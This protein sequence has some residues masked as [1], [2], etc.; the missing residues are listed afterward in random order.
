MILWNS[1][2]SHA[3][4]QNHCKSEEGS[5]H[6]N[7]KG[8]GIDEWRGGWVTAVWN[9]WRRGRPSV[10]KGVHPASK[11]CVV[12]QTMW[13]NAWVSLLLIEILLVRGGVEVNPGPMADQGGPMDTDPD[14]AFHDVNEGTDQVAA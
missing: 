3:V 11:G 1:I 6:S 4:P 12:F 2:P 8:I 10:P 14:C 7:I 9:V 5:P 13:F